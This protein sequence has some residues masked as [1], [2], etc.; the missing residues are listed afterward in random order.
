MFHFKRLPVSA[1]LLAVALATLPPGAAQAAETT[2]PLTINS[3]GHEITFKQAPARTVSV[4]QSTT[5][6]LYLLGVADKVV[7]TA[8]WI[9][10]VLKGYEDANAKVER[11]AD[12]DP[13]FEAVVG[14]R[15]DLVTTQ[16]QWQIGPEG[17]VG[18]PEQF[19]EL[20]I[21][22]YTSPA[23][24]MGKDN[25]G[26]GDG[27]RKSVFTMDLIYQEV[28]DLAKIF[29][30]QDRGE[31]VVADL[32]KREE[33]ARA[34]IASANG[35][36]SAV[37]WFSSAELDI[38][39]YVAG[40]NGAPG[41]IMSALGLKNVIE[42]DEEWPTV[43]W[44]TIAKANPSVIVAGKMDRRRFPADDVAV[45]LKFLATDPVASIMPA[46]KAAHVFEMDAQA[47]NPTIRTIEGIE[48]LAEAI[49]TA[50]LAK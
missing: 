32:K 28:R 7:G 23:D 35:K 34:K 48:T 2:Y 11:L 47:M 22:V 5:E 29:N 41:Y 3:C 24:C 27:V 38:D 12:N 49:S 46:V 31:E 40:R 16:F 26:G 9:G 10:P 44:E 39:P 50:G 21:P 4:G 33:A 15:P 45:K 18:T 36:I 19:A 43:G 17:V 6:V 20:G 37:F 25:S 1:G 13:S 30:V 42:S 8:L 14:K